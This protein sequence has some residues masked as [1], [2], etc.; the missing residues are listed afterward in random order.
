MSATKTEKAIAADEARERSLLTG[1]V[2]REKGLCPLVVVRTR[3]AGVHVGWLAEYDAASRT[4]VLLESRRIWRW[5][6][7][8]TLSE[9]AR[10]GVEMEGTRIARPIP[11]HLVADVSEI[12]P[13]SETAAPS[14]TASRWGG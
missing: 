14:L 7:A 6:G 10:D 5:Y 4:A 1:E 12:L 13:V 8:Y 2:L 9:V 11:H 3:G